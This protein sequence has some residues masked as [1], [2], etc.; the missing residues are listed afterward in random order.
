[1]VN[2]ASN[3]EPQHT[4]QKTQRLETKMMTYSCARCIC[5]AAIISIIV[6][7]TDLGQKWRKRHIHI[8]IHSCN[9]HETYRV[10]NKQTNV[11]R[12]KRKII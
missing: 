8:I 6:K 2:I 7:F 9:A 1:M 3:M 5:P 4:D 12:N 10:K 11:D